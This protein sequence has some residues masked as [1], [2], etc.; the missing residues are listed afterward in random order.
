[1]NRNELIEKMCR[2]DCAACNIPPDDYEEDL[3]TGEGFEAG[4]GRRLYNW[5]HGKDRMEALLKIVEA[6]T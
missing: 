6:T 2:A 5:E 4:T 3:R 1:M